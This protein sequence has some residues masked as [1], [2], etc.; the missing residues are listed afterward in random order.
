MR[1]Q[2]I[3]TVLLTS[4]LMGG[5]TIVQAPDESSARPRP[6]QASMPQGQTMKDILSAHANQ[7]S[8]A[9]VAEY[10]KVTVNAPPAN[11]LTNYVDYTRSQQK[12]LNGIF[13]RLPNPDMCMYVYPHL[14]NEQATVPGYTS[15]F[16]LYDR[17]QYALPGEMN[18]AW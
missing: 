17:N 12:E 16:P 11:G 15:C 1:Q 5:C 14:S 3:Y 2:T 4:I 8:V 10:R 7:S 6:T 18:A 13:P 9:P